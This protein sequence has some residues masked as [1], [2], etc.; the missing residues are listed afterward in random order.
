VSCG[1]HSHPAVGDPSKQAI[2]A[3]WDPRLRLQAEEKGND[4]DVK[5]EGKELS[6]A[7][8]IADGRW[9]LETLHGDRE[10]LVKK[11]CFQSIPSN[12]PV[13]KGGPHVVSRHGAPIGQRRA[14]L[15]SFSFHSH[16]HTSARIFRPTSRP[17]RN[18]SR[19]AFT[20]SFWG[21]LGKGG[22]VPASPEVLLDASMRI[23]HF[24]YSF[25]TFGATGKGR[26]PRRGFPP[27][28][29]P[30]GR[31]EGG[32]PTSTGKVA[33]TQDETPHFLCFSDRTRRTRTRGAEDFCGRGSR[34]TRE[35]RGMLFGK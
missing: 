28:P 3:A 12:G 19:A 34:G 15:R 33:E 1:T 5:G 25:R 13:F 9:P 21:K 26:P 23:F 24:I 29:R 35:M 22:N 7:S 14:L 32:K 4:R 27:S 17:R 2:L 10:R 20:G 31:W 11:S 18:T 8:W 16:A 30:R 6:C